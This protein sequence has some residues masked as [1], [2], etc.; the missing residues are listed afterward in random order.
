MEF[1]TRGTENMPLEKLDRA[2]RD[3]VIGELV[4]PQG[5]EFRPVDNL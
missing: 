1:N 3:V 5:G 2:A 4:I